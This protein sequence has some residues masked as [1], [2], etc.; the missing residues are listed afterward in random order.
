MSKWELREIGF[1]DRS[2]CISKSLCFSKRFMKFSLK[3]K[4]KK[5]N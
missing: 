1:L 2:K 4:I 3:R 5:P